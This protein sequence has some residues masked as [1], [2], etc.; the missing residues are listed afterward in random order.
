MS[1]VTVKKYVVSTQEESDACRQGVCDQFLA[2][3]NENPGHT[4]NTT[5]WSNEKYRSGDGKY[6]IP[7]Y[8]NYSNP[9]NYP[10]E[11]T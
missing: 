2:D 5:A 10:T 9:D 1:R 7:F 6:L 11:D 4:L 3:H 8:A